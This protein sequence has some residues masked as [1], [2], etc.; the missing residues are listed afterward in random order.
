MLPLIRLLRP[1][2]W[3]KN[4]L[5]F[6]PLAF[7]GELLQ[8]TQW[9]P[10]LLAFAGLC[11][12]SSAGYIIND[13]Y[14]APADRRN[15]EK[16]SRPLASGAVSPLLAVLLMVILLCTGALVLWYLSPWAALIGT[17]ML[18]F[19]T[20]YTVLLRNEPV[21]DVCVLGVNFV[22][23]AGVGA[24]VLAVS[25]SSWLVLCAFFMALVLSVGKRL[26]ETRL[27]GSASASH[28]GSLAGYTPENALLL[29]GVSSAV[30]LISYALYSFIHGPELLLIT[31]PFAFY[32]V[33]RHAMLAAQGAKAARHPH[34]LLLDWRMVAAVVS[35]GALTMA[36]LY[37]F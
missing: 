3:Y 21:L 27:L 31:L 8:W 15:P 12:L 28:R 13:L 25:L 10:V 24:I 17:V 4:L 23:R 9:W 30:L 5:V 14:D 22:I 1:E 16:R 33:M 34:L 35:W 32:A 29:M 11:L 26:A 20:A 37:F 19:T 2:Q 7:V 6:V 18:G 36:I